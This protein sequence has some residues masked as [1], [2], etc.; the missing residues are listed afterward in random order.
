MDTEGDL[1]ALSRVLAVI[2][3]GT[4]AKSI[5]L[6]SFMLQDQVLPSAGPCNNICDYWVATLLHLP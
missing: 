5:V 1:M 3:L 2:N 4:S 6:I